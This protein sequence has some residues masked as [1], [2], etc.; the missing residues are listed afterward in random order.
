[1][2]DLHRQAR[3]ECTELL[4]AGQSTGQFEP[5]DARRVKHLILERLD[6][7]AAVLEATQVEVDMAGGWDDEERI[8]REGVSSAE[9]LLLH[10]L[11]M[12]KSVERSWA[13]NA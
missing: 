13:L 10:F 6:S 1:M 12:L 2:R 3:S 4:E 5:D 11:D 8:V 9:T 7:A